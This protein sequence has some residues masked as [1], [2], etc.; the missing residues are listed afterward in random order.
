MARI[1]PETNT[2]RI[3]KDGQTMARI[4]TETNAIRIKMVRQWLG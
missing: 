1:K 4:K 2:I 3:C